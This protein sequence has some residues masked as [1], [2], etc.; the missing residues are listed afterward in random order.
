MNMYYWDTE[1]GEFLANA[2]SVEDARQKILN[3]L[4]QNDGAYTDLKEALEQEPKINPELT[5]FAWMH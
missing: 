3:K 1:M 4:G 2:N 5:V